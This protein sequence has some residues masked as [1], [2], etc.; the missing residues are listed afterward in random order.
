ME[1][2]HTTSH[3]LKPI[4]G[5]ALVGLGLVLLLEKLDGPAAQLTNLLGAAAR[6]T[7]ELLPSF[8]PAAGQAL[9]AYVG[10]IL[11]AAPRRGR[12]V[13]VAGRFHG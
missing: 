9:Q 10:I 1:R 3:S 13:I 5:A 2:E 12:S 7:L 11:A 8:V 4:A 6:E